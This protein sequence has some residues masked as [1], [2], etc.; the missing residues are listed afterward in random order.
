MA[1]CGC[2]QSWQRAFKGLP[3]QAGTARRWAGSRAGHADAEQ[4]L[5][6]LFAA[7]LSAGPD[8]V[9]VTVSTAG[10]RVRITVTGSERLPARLPS[11]LGRTIVAA[12]S[13][14]SGTTPDGC[15]LWAQLTTE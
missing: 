15:G 4:V 14:R 2:G 11:G 1:E 10:S 5:G 6:E 3:Q 9:T 13:A 8:L 12:L 7:V